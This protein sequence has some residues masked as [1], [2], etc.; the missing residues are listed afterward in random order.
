MKASFLI[1]LLAAGVNAAQA[2]D[3]TPITSYRE[4]EGVKIPVISFEDGQRKVNWQPPENWQISGGDRELNLYP[5]KLP[6]A[7]A[8]LKLIPHG[9]AQPPERT[10]ALDSLLK[11]AMSFVPG[12]ATGITFDHEVPN[13]F[14]LDGK[15]SRE[16]TFKYVSDA[17]KCCTSVAL[18][19]L[20]A[21]QSLALV[22]T[23]RAE[24][25]ERAYRAWTS[26]MF[27]WQWVSRPVS[28]QDVAAS[29]VPASKAAR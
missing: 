2:L 13:P 29:N 20:D 5:N 9:A 17:K 1:G 19:D 7:A 21:R 26:S 27:R 4:L 24:D 8:Q 25:F 6:L 28:A 23:A 11:W 3:L 18:V 12:D 22:I 16:L 10:A 15:P 14:L